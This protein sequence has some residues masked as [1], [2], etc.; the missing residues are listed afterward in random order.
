MCANECPRAYVAQAV[1]FKRLTDQKKDV[2]KN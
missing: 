2:L 1:G